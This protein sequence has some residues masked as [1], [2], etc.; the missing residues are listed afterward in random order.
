MTKKQKNKKDPR[1]RHGT[2]NLGIT[3]PLPQK[4]T[5]H[6]Y[7]ILDKARRPTRQPTHPPSAITKLQ[8]CILPRLSLAFGM[9]EYAKT[10]RLRTKRRK[11][12]ARVWMYAARPRHV[13]VGPA[14]R[15]PRPADRP[16]KKA[17]ACARACACFTPGKKTRGTDKDDRQRSVRYTASI[18][19]VEKKTVFRGFHSP[20][21]LGR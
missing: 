12:R 10:K 6:L 17:K 16:T 4:H 2:V 14:G 11:K 21:G 9:C 5:P 15:P 18:G 8:S 13:L 7:C 20:G 1:S 19:R 3:Q